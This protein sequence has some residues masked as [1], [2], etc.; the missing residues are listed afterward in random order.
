[1]KYNKKLQKRLNL[2]INDYKEYYQSIEIEL[3]IAEDKYGE[4]I[5]IPDEEKEYYHI[6]FNNS[7]EEIKRNYLNENDKDKTIKIIIDYQIKSFKK[8]FYNCKCIDSIY[9]KK[10]YRNNIT[11]MC[12][13]F[14][15]CFSLKELNFSNFVTDSITDMS[16]M[17][18]GCSSLKELNL[19]NFNTINVTNMSGMFDGCSSLIELN[20]TNFNTNNVTHMIWMFNGCPDTLIKKIKKQN[21]NLIII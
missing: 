11:D 6:Y 15:D 12:L 2:S 18:S 16:G 19:S 20:L 14:H 3:K 4:F 10:F 17:F 1:M 21:K 9:F 5:N 8:L 7:N 13:M